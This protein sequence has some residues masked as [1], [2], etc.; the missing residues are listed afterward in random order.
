[1]A[2]VLAPAG[3][4]EGAV[5]VAMEVHDVEALGFQHSHHLRAPLFV[6]AHHAQE[7][8]FIK[9]RE[10]ELKFSK[11]AARLNLESSSMHRR[12]A[13]H[14]RNSRAGP[15]VEEQFNHLGLAV[16]TCTHEGTLPRPGTNCT[17]RPKFDGPR[18][19]VCCVTRPRV[20]V[21]D[22]DMSSC[23]KFT[24]GLNIFL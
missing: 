5:P 19:E 4:V 8:A 15:R 17:V 22:V 20:L 7:A 2:L 23:E 13:I 12:V 21:V 10:A 24:H 16:E 3:A 9:M 14:F 1:M 6:H 18:S 11:G